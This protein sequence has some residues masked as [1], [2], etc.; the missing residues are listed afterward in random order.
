[1]LTDPCGNPLPININLPDFIPIALPVP[2]TLAEL[3]KMLGLTLPQPDAEI[4]CPIL[5]DRATDAASA[6]AP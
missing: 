5:L 3:L 2:P 6:A 4:P 1:M